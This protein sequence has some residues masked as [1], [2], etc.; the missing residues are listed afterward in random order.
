MTNEFYAQEHNL[1][2]T[3]NEMAEMR[4]GAK[5]K[6]KRCNREYDFDIPALVLKHGGETRLR[7][8]QRHAKCRFCDE[9]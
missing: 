4:L 5:F 1:D 8:I 2:L 9:T 7:F 6:C 3:L